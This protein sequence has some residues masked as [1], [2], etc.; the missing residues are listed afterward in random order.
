MLHRPIFCYVS[1]AITGAEMQE[2]NGRDN[3]D[4]DARVRLR[5]FDGNDERRQYHWLLLV[6]LL[7]LGY[8]FYTQ[9]D[10]VRAMLTPEPVVEAT[11]PAPAPLPA[12]SSIVSVAAPAARI[13]E[14]SRPTVETRPEVV[15]PPKAAVLPP[16][17]LPV[18][19]STPAEPARTRAAGKAGLVEALRNGELRLANAG[20]FGRWKGSHARGGGRY[21]G[22]SFDESVAHMEAYVVQKDFDIPAGLAGADAV[23]FLLETR[24]PFPR[25][26]AGHSPILD[27]HSG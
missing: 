8:G 20:D 4:D 12:A 16:P 9:F 18:A 3:Q 2:G 22:R 15:P 21:P 23:V 13:P 6:P 7:A 10:R 14:P 25:G 27:I 26:D 11:P 24:A 5:T 17:S 19:Y 1:A